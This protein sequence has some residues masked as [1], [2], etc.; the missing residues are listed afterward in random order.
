[1]IAP[2]VE[3][4]AALGG[5]PATQVTA[6]KQLKNDIV[7]HELRKE[8]IVKNGILEPLVRIIENGSSGKRR[9]RDGGAPLLAIPTDEDEARLQ[10][11]LILG[12]IADGG[13]AFVAPLKA[14][15]VP[16]ALVDSL[17]T[18]TAPKLVTATLRVLKAIGAANTALRLADVTDIGLQSALF[19]RESN[20]IYLEILRQPSSSSNGRQQ[21]RLVADIVA[22][23][24][25]GEQTKASL[26][27]TGVLDTMASLLAAFA[28]ANRH[29]DSSGPAINVPAPP[30]VAIPNI[31]AAVTTIITG[32]S[33][34]LHRF[35]LS[36]A[37]RELFGRAGNG[38]G[39]QKHTF[40]PKC[41]FLDPDGEPLLPP[42][43]IQSVGTTTYHSAYSNAFPAQAALQSQRSKS[44]LSSFDMAPQGMDT[45][46]A[47]AVCG[48]L[49]VLARSMQGYDR[50]LALKVLA[51]VN[52][53]IDIDPTGTHTNSRSEHTQKTRER[54][55]Q[56][57]L[58]AV[59]LAVKLVQ[60]AADSKTVP[61]DENAR[62][63]REEACH[64]LARL[65]SSH[66]DLQVAAME[67]GAIR[68]VCP[69]LKKTFDNVTLAKPMW[70]AS[71]K[72]NTN[73]SQAETRQLGPRGL[74]TEILHVMKCREG[75]LLAIASLTE[76]EDTHR[77]AI[78]DA[79]VVPCIIE[80]LKMFS[81]D[82]SNK[83]ANNRTQIGVSDG[84]TATVILA[85][86]LAAKA[87]SRSVSLLRTSLIDAGIAKPIAALLVHQNPDI[88]LAATDVCVNLLLEFSP[89]RETLVEEGVIKTLTA[90][91]KS[92]SPQ[93]KLSSLWALKHLVLSNKREVKIS[94]FEE[95]GAG[96]LVG[97]I[98]GD[99]DR[100]PV[101]SNGGG[102][103]IGV[104]GS[105]AAGEQVDLLNP[106]STSMDVDDDDEPIDDQ[107]EYDEE[108]GEGQDEDGEVMYDEASST[109]YL[110]S[111]L[112]STLQPPAS[113]TF[114]TKK[115]LSSV[116]EMEEN[117]TLQAR[118][119]D[120][121]VQEQ[122]LDFIRN[123][124]NGDEDCAFMLDYM[125]QQIGTAKF[126]E[127]L[128]TKLSPISSSLRLGSSEK[129]HP[130]DGRPLYNPNSI[131]YA[132]ACII[133][134]IGNC[135]PRHK[136]LLIAQKPLLQAWKAHFTHHERRIRVMCVWAVNSL[137]WID[138]E[139]DKKDARQRAME[140][141]T[142][143][144][145]AEV[146]K[147]Q[148]DTDLDVKE[149][150]RTAMRQFEQLL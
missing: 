43:H 103:S 105:N 92:S 6:L 144:I 15:D 23:A 56:L 108:A 95:L 3:A 87:M 72:A 58:L 65:I 150:V 47:N 12:S 96:F 18:N 31:L 11:T 66:K 125:L 136:Q 124:L 128:T 145:E 17:A 98:Q 104:S 54:E 75:A 70:S 48:W 14:A 69:M 21:L 117:P 130:W 55:R 40:G 109:H 22:T 52:N 51:H 137:T 49:L 127:L 42:I 142:M 102:V 114:N 77:K 63:I 94:I 90:H 110:A 141:R 34:R 139:A 93:L 46:H 16:R 38:C 20:E 41:G 112:R 84:N 89:M 83:L 36:P 135:L 8:L 35:L 24:A 33:Y 101:A 60:T 100:V 29:V 27:Q 115:Y 107:A 120:V 28:V 78:V 59:P 129:P 7:G 5:D 26:V 19:N 133:T 61:G 88:Q 76:Q 9:R 91:A 30:L 25:A 39:D 45:D 126:F 134:H 111:Q 37:F 2:S 122:A 119:E 67:A 32:S 44:G 74:P 64:V 73:E 146:R 50:L 86:C 121:D 68:H 85:A 99:Q 4:I 118:R 148:N 140:L 116:R 143:G 62:L 138:D 97:A 81:A 106:T 13:P 131:L 149:R 79:G 1:M 132:A 57:A 10:A 147:L 82:L 53:A 113:Q 80:S 123:T 71:K